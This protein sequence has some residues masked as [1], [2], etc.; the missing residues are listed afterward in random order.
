MVS[1]AMRRRPF[2]Q[3]A[4]TP[5]S[6]QP[7]DAFSRSLAPHAPAI[8]DHVTDCRTGRRA[9][10]TG[11]LPAADGIL[12]LELRDDS[13]TYWHA[14]ADEVRAAPSTAEAGGRA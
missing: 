11:H 8:G 10:V 6:P 3:L 7:G 5:Q 2:D 13:E 14:P 12:R 1:T 9:E 4:E